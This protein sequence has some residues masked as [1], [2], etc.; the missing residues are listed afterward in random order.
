M[1]LKQYKLNAKNSCVSVNDA[2][3]NNGWFLRYQVPKSVD[4]KSNFWTLHYENWSL[5]RGRR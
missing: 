3:Y 1:L 5:G 4:A 2:Q